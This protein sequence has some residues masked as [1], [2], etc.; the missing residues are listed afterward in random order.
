M[1][2]LWS[3][4]E[5]G[6]PQNQQGQ[7]ESHLNQAFMNHA[8]LAILVFYLLMCASLRYLGNHLIPSLEAFVTRIKI[9]D[10]HKLCLIV[11]SKVLDHLICSGSKVKL[12]AA[13]IRTLITDLYP[14]HLGGG[15]WQ[16]IHW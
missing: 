15:R 14:G 2:V 4:V 16:L 1:S 11:P 7:C 9:F 6:S 3:T 12:A 13:V 10:Q 5:K 8:L